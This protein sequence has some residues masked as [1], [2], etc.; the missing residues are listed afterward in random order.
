MK[1]HI[2][3][4]ETYGPEFDAYTGGAIGNDKIVEVPDEKWQEYR[5]L[6]QALVDME[7]WMESLPDER[8]TR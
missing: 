3:D 5:V 1:I 7:E 6:R 2:H 4:E 8:E